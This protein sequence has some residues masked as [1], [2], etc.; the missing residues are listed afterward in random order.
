LQSSFPSFI[1]PI[2]SLQSPIP[3]LQSKVHH[4]VEQEICIFNLK[5]LQQFK[6]YHTQHGCTTWPSD[7][8]QYIRSMQ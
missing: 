4:H 8:S 1:S 3:S 5:Y 2:P 6:L 7:F